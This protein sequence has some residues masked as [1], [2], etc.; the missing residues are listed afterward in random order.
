[1]FQK[2][3]MNTR[4]LVWTIGNASER[5]SIEFVWVPQSIQSD[6]YGIKCMQN[7][8]RSRLVL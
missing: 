2:G 1:M 4:K 6:L 7:L 8:S 5:R 3:N